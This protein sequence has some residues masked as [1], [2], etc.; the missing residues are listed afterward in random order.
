MGNGGLQSFV[1]LFPGAQG[2]LADSC[3]QALTTPSQLPCTL[4]VGLVPLTPAGFA[5]EGW[6]IGFVCA[7]ILLLL[8]LL[9]LCFIKRSKGG[10]YSGNKTPQ[11][12]CLQEPCQSILVEE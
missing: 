1:F 4:P 5:T 3:L 8:I 12:G 10:K 9:I 11:E 2:V 7:I 6:F